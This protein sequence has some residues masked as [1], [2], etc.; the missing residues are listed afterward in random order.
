MAKVSF[1]GA[2]PG[3][4]ELLTLKA[5]ARIRHAG[6]ILFAGSLVPPEAFRPHTTL[7]GE[8]IIDSAP[9]TLE[10]THALISKAIAAGQDVA[11]LHTGD[12]SIYG[13]IN[14]QMNLLDR[15]GIAYEVVPGI[16]SAMAAAAALKVEYTAPGVT[17]TVIFTRM[18][19]K[20]PVPEEE[21]LVSLAAHKAT[22]VIFLSAG[23]AGKVAEKLIRHYDS[24]TPAAVVHRVGWP[25]EQC[26]FT[27]LGNLASAVKD[28]GIS[29]QALIIVGRV[30]DRQTL[31]EARSR[32]YDQSFSHGYRGK[33]GYE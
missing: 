8:R 5:V 20:T 11:R 6:L 13:A 27:T 3:D 32:L 30:V 2:G 4:P 9:L 14:E 19:G 33:K 23:K 28:A 31:K 1:I 25:D 12:P 7:P 24:G 16:S 18:A 29:R 17:Q 10:E 15:D 26:I 22:M 21:E